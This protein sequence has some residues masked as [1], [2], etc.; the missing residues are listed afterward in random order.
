MVTLRL[1]VR[2]LRLCLLG[3]SLC[4]GGLPAG[5]KGLSA[6]CVDGGRRLY[7]GL[8]LRLAARSHCLLGLQSRPLRV[9]SR[10]LRFRRRPLRIRTS[11]C[12]VGSCELRGVLR[13]RR[14]RGK[15]GHPA[16]NL[17]HRVLRRDPRLSSLTHTRYRLRLGRL[18]CE[19]CSRRLRVRCRRLRV[20]RRR[21]RVRRLHRR[22]KLGARVRVGLPT[23][24][25]RVRRLRARVLHLRLELLR[26]LSRLEELSLRRVHLTPERRA[27]RDGLAAR[28]GERRL[29]AR[30]VL[31]QLRLPLACGAAEDRVLLRTLIL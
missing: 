8:F 18:G 17:G 16:L 10:E 9:G 28:R 5:F 29:S 26:Q 1:S 30:L 13:R 4:R 2:E 31:A 23:R 15:L 25:A 27:R 11:I 19:V 21:L 3:S 22:D 24:L 12:H 6:R 7:P 20:R 14:R